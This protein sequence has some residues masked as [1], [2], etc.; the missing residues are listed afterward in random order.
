MPI[1]IIKH[2]RIVP[3]VILGGAFGYA[4]YR[5]FLKNRMQSSLAEHGL[6][7]SAAPVKAQVMWANG[8]VEE[9]DGGEDNVDASHLQD[10]VVEGVLDSAEHQFGNQAR[11][12]FPAKV[13]I[14]H[15]KKHYSGEI[16]IDEEGYPILTMQ[17]VSVK[18]SPIYS[19]P[20]NTK[21]AKREK[22]AKDSMQYI[23]SREN[24]QPGQKVNDFHAPIPA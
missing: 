12:A 23:R 4:F 10:Y 21:H 22:H 16:T 24:V 13:N 18:K 11:N 15:G 1:E 7:G 19:I 20:A 6:S 2:P 17:D 3:A 8:M 14:A 5:L 9:M